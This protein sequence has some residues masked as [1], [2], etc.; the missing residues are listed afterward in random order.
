MR[1]RSVAE[2]EELAAGIKDPNFRIFA[3]QGELHVMNRDG[4][5]RGT[6]PFEIFKTLGAV[7]PSHAFYLGYEMAKAVAALTLGKNYQQDE[8]LQWG[9]L[10][11]TEI[12]LR[13]RTG[14]EEEG[15]ASD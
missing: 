2:L 13:H 5:R 6:D 14:Q 4:Y 9:F 12:S 1:E 3:E 8:A 11:R 10:T 7:D 15:K